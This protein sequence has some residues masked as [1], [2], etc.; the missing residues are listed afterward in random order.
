[1]DSVLIRT[2]VCVAIKN[3][4]VDGVCKFWEIIDEADS[5]A[6]GLLGISFT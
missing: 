2:R 1:M 5:G 6:F 4:E 3:K